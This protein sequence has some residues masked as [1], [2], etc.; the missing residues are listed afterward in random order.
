MADPLG[1]NT[2]IERSG[3]P[4]YSNQL[5]LATPAI[6][7]ESNTPRAPNPACAPESSPFGLI[8]SSFF[9]DLWNSFTQTLRLTEASI[10]RIRY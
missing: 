4:L 7:S 1:D 10:L 5:G 3:W 2:V 8:R 6:P 9:E